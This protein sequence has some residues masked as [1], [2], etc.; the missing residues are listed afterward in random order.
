MFIDTD[1][2]LFFGRRRTCQLPGIGKIKRK[3]FRIGNIN[4]QI[5]PL[6]LSVDTDFAFESFLRDLE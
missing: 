2:Q 3:D 1:K 4:K 5:F 6:L